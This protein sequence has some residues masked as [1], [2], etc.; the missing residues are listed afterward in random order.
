MCGLKWKAIDL[1]NATI[2]IENN[3]QYIE[4]IGLVAGTPKTDVCR[5]VNIAPELVALLNEYGKSRKTVKQYC[6]RILKTLLNGIS[7]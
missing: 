3:V 2:R 1:Q 6:F 7:R 4:G 5:T